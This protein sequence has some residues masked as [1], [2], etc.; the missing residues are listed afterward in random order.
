M[1]LLVGT[2]NSIDLH[3][4]DVIKTEL[5]LFMTFHT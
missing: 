4:M 2:I 5:V 1:Q 3:G